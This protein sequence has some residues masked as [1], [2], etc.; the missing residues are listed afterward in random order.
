MAKFKRQLRVSGLND[1]IAVDLVDEDKN[2]IENVFYFGK[3]QIVQVL[4]KEHEEKFWVKTN[5]LFD[6]N[7]LILVDVDP[8]SD[9]MGMEYEIEQKDYEFELCDEFNIKPCKHQ[10]R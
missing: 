2:I 7:K 4:V 1:Y 6:G 5:V 10:Q 9:W 8:N 3:N